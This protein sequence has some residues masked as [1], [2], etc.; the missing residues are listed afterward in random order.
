MIIC[1]LYTCLSTEIIILQ[2]ITHRMFV[3]HLVYYDRAM[4]YVSICSNKVISLDRRNILKDRLITLYT[5][6]YNFIS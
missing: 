2:M 1:Y 6:M 3:D 5:Y 4:L